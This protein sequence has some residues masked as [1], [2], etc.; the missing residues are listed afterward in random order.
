MFRFKQFAVAQNNCAMKVNTDGVLLGAWVEVSEAKHILD[1]GTGTGVIALMLAQKNSHAVI[2]AIDIDKDAYSQSK[3][4][5]EQSPWS[6]SLT[7]IHSSLQN[8]KGT[9]AVYPPLVEVAS[10]SARDEGGSNV[11]YDSIISNPPY[12]IDDFKADNSQKNIAKHSTALTYQELLKGINRLLSKTGK[13]FLVIPVFNVQLI[14]TLAAE[15]NL[16][17]TKFT[18]VTAVAGK[19]PYLAL[20]ELGRKKEEYIKSSLVI[21]DTQGNFTEE[22]KH[23]TKDFYLKF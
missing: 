4:N 3:E 2:D 12:F 14:Q 10:G 20:M 18:E 8:Y 5:F 22:Y 19:N 7:A 6:N 9:L 23:L 1:I 11:Y 17:I 15:E 13:A 16:Y 21:Q